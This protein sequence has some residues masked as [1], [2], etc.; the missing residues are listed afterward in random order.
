MSIN[1]ILIFGASSAIASAIAR[2]YAGMQAGFFLVG[3]D[4]PVMGVSDDELHRINIPTT[5]VPYYDRMHPYTTSVHAHKT[6]PNSRFFDFNPLRR[7][8]MDITPIDVEHDEDMV[9]SI[10]CEMYKK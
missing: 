1:N 3:K 2:R 9:V 6:I 10:L 5:I 4:Q 7:E 8:N